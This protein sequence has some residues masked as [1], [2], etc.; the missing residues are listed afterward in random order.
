MSPLWIL[1]ELMMM[2]VLVTA[3]A[4]RHAKLQSKCQHQQTNIQ[5]FYRPDA[6][7]VAQSTVLK[8]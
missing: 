1:M 3:G 2:A 8:H 6:L 5:F 7:S 4:I